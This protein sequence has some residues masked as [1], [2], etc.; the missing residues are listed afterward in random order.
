MLITLPERIIYT[1]H[2]QCLHNVE[3]QNALQQGIANRD[4]PLTYAGEL[5]SE[6]TAK[7]IS[8]EFPEIDSVFCSTYSR[9]RAIPNSSGYASS[10][11]QDPLLDERNMGIW[12]NY[13][14]EDVLKMYPSEE[15]RLRSVG[16]YA[17]SAPEGESCSDVEHRLIKF[18][19]SD[20][21]NSS[22]STVYISGH[23]ISGLC[24]RRL[25]TGASLD[26]WHEWT[27]LKNASVTVYERRNKFY[28]CSMYN[29]VPWEG[30][31]DQ[32]LLTRKSTEA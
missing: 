15:E 3:H 19:T 28:T 11:I 17:Y 2:P 14:R 26:D 9:T 13:L 16:Y 32:T 22:D 7:Y 20:I 8:K 21:L 30:L 10:L 24:L 5:Q 27:R 18:L 6:I 4:S 25:L 23:G 12:H 31:I 29:F 1:R